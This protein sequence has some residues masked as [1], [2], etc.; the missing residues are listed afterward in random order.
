MIFSETPCLT[1]AAY[2]ILI[3]GRAALQAF[4]IPIKVCSEIEDTSCLRLVMGIS[5]LFTDCLEKRSAQ[6]CSEKAYARAKS[7]FYCFYFS[8]PLSLWFFYFFSFV[9]NL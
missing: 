8:M 3:T 5:L 4:L 2:Q 1:S 6:C 7:H 9:E